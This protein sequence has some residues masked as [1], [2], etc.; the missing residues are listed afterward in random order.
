[1]L[2]SNKFFVYLWLFRA[3]CTPF[4]TSSMTTN[5]KQK[6]KSA[7]ENII[8]K[9]LNPLIFNYVLYPL[10]IGIECIQNNASIRSSFRCILY[11]VKKFIASN[12]F[13]IQQQYIPTGIPTKHL[14]LYGSIR[15]EL[16]SKLS[17]TAK[18]ISNSMEHVLLIYMKFKLFFYAGCPNCGGI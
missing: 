1:M 11:V 16:I 8:H 13:H 15:T 17:K 6:T 9:L 12:P 18:N 5:E 10:C 7:G 3:H 4:P 2:C 14:I